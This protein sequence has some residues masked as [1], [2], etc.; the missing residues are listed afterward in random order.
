MSAQRDLRPAEEPKAV[1]AS[2]PHFKSF[3]DIAD[4]RVRRAKE[5][6]QV[7]MFA[8]DRAPA[9]LADR[10]APEL[11]WAREQQERDNPSDRDRVLK[12]IRVEK[13]SRAEIAEDTGLPVATVYKHLQELMSGGLVQARQL[14][15]RGGRGGNN[16]VVYQQ[17]QA[18]P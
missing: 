6:E 18:K 4:P 7:L 17:V 2:T 13:L 16:L 10:L 8:I 3:N 9:E 11:K 14:P 12:S 15:A 1:P 5:Y